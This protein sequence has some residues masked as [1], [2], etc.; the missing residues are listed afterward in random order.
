L[1]LGPVERR[2][3]LTAGSLCL[4]PS[5]QF[6]RCHRLEK[7]GDHACVDWVGRQMLTN[8]RILVDV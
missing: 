5:F 4:F 8:R 1:H 3:G 6:G 2:R 7:G